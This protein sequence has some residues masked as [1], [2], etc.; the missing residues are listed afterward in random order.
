MT[1]QANKCIR[2]ALRIARTLM[3]VADEGDVQMR[4]DGCA[5][6][7]CVMRDCA[8]RLRKQAEREREAH[9]AKGIWDE[10]DDPAA[11]DPSASA[12]GFTL[13]GFTVKGRPEHG[14][15]G[16]KSEDGTKP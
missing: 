8:Y 14:R 2:R 15:M 13:N 16:D 10:A 12:H 6:L 9:R 7:Y 11:P 3:S 4:D 1:S 5:V